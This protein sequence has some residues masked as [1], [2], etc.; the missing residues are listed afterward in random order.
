[1]TATAER[2]LRDLIASVLED[3]GIGFGADGHS[4]EVEVE[5]IAS[6]LEKL[7]VTERL[8]NL[9][10][11]TGWTRAADARPVAWDADNWADRYVW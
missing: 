11:R 1:M 10:V 5:A 4:Y 6:A 3:V 2:S 7:P 9:R 8:T